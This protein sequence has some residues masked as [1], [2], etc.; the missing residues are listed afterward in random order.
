MWWCEGARVDSPGGA[1][2]D[3][4]HE[5]HR[6][7]GSLKLTS[8]GGGGPWREGGEDCQ[9]RVRGEGC[10]WRMGGRGCQWGAGGE[11]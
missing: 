11:G 6:G 5:G 10:W 9:W 3:R 2:S 7:I 4:G 8:R 1:R